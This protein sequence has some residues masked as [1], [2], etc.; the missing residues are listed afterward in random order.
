MHLSNETVRKRKTFAQPSHATLECSDIVGYLDDIIEW[1]AGD[2]L[3]L[4][5]EQIRE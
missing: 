4:K 2:L 3:E 5:Q 1:S